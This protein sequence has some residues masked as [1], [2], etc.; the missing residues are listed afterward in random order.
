MTNLPIFKLEEFWKKYEFSSP[1]LLC[2]SDAESW[3]LNDILSM[4]DAESKSLWDHLSLGYTE[5]PGLPLLRQEIAQLYNTLTADDI[6]TTAGAEEGIYCAMQSLISSGDH[7]IVVSP[8]YQSLETL[9]QILG[10]DITFIQLQAAKGWKLSCEEIQSAW[11]PS[12]KL[13]TVVCPHN[14][15]GILLEAN[16]YEKMISLARTTG[17]HI[18]CDEVYRFLE[19]DESKRLPAI[20]D[21]YEKGISLNVMTKSFGL[22]G[23]RIGWLASKDHD[24]LQKANSY[25]MYTSI[26]NSAPSEILA[27]I[28]L[29]SK[30]RILGRNREI[31]LKNVSILDEF[32]KRHPTSIRWVR[33]E[34]GTVAFLE[35]LLPISIDDFTVQLVQE[36]GVLIMPASV[37]DFSGNF[38]R[39]G[40]GRKNMP[41]ILNRFEQFLVTYENLF[42]N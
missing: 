21:A 15:T 40:M 19:I 11:R 10:A 13:L 27:L 42:K 2:P 37:F 20:A 39:I 16:V 18:F 5:S 4:A 1:Y 35:L 31:V 34:G 7:V 28:A 26:C 33:P 41:D 3:L 32:V 23:L 24:L 29:R 25:K 9:P 30:E 36:T 12:T 14:P 8:T 6:F 17:A 22:S 38:F